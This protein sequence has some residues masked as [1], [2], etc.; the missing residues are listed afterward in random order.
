MSLLPKAMEI[1]RFYPAYDIRAI[2]W[3]NTIMPILTAPFAVPVFRFIRSSIPVQI[4]RTLSPY[5]ENYRMS[6]D[7]NEWKKK[8]LIIPLHLLHFGLNR[9]HAGALEGL[10]HC[11]LFYCISRFFPSAWPA[12]SVC[13]EL[14]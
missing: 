9:R 8:A 5:L 12:S 2:I 1:E 11:F 6:S 7:D 3:P 10:R 4:L 13:E 14:K